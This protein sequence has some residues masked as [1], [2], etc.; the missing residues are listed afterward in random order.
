MIPVGGNP[1]CMEPVHKN[2]WPVDA[3][4]LLRV[5]RLAISGRFAGMP[6]LLICHSIITFTRF[7]KRG[8]Y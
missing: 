7:L 3:M 1:G 4:L 8:P 6:D 5:T 2:R